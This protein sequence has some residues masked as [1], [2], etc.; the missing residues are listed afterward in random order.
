[1]KCS[2]ILAVKVNGNSI[3]KQN[4]A[5]KKEK[6][7]ILFKYISVY[8]LKIVKHL[9]SLRFTKNM[10]NFIHNIRTT[11]D[12]YT[13]LITPLEPEDIHVENTITFGMNIIWHQLILKNLSSMFESCI[14]GHWSHLNEISSIAL[15]S[16]VNTQIFID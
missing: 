5:K 1:M 2:A 3:S 13:S 10:L 8:L 4:N 6:K 16:I 9:F 7:I 12:I 11:N 14:G 15:V